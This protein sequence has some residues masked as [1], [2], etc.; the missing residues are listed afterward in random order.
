MIITTPPSWVDL[1]D[2]LAA[3]GML[4]EPWRAAFL[5]VPREVFIPEVIWRYAGDDLVPLRR[6]A[7]PEEWLR[8]VYGPRYVVTQV[9]DGTPAG[10]DG[11]GRVPTSSASRPDIV[12]LMLAAGHVEP[13]MRVLEIGTGTGYTAALLAH[14]LGARNV[15]TIEID[16]TLAARARTAL[17]TA[18]YGDV[19]V[20]TGDGARGYPAQAPFDRVL[21]TVA[22][23]QVPYE[24]VA[25]TRTNGRV[26][27]PWSST[28]KPAGLL[29]VTIR[30]DGTATGGLLNTTVSFMPLRDQRTTRSA[31]TDVVRDTDT[32]DVSDTDLHVSDVL[33]DDAP[34]AIAIQVP[35]CH[36]EYEPASDDDHW[37]VWFLDPGS[38][39]WARFD[40]QPGR[41]RRPVHQFGPRRL[42]DEVAAAY[43]QWDHAGRP[44]VTQWRF[45]LTPDSG[46]WSWP[47]P[48][49][50]STRLPSPTD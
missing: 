29:S 33:N 40:Y 10:P 19:T 21:S 5:A 16:P 18:G 17:T 39:S 44:P 49:A 36:W 3:Q 13:G 37:S 43:H 47:A 42:W 50:T 9:D 35:G 30:A 4:G 31:R 32:P 38:R 48:P 8:R 15:T 45:T 20:I 41:R 28:Y 2:G 23:P 26:V 25:Q 14:Y 34:F 12:A 22:A 24:W 27:T 1:V 11:R 6:C 7:D 46:M